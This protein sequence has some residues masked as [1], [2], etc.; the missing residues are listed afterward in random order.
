MPLAHWRSITRAP[1]DRL[2]PRILSPA[3]GACA[4]ARKRQGAPLTRLIGEDRALPLYRR[5]VYLCSGKQDCPSGRSGQ[6]H[7]THD[8]SWL[9]WIQQSRASPGKISTLCDS[10]ASSP[11]GPWLKCPLSR[12]IQPLLDTRNKYKSEMKRFSKGNSEYNRKYAMQ[13]SINGGVNT[14]YGTMASAYFD[15]SEQR[16]CSNAHHALLTTSRIWHAQPAA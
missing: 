1:I 7:F 2:Q 10:K 3:E 14:L 12:F 15:I 8:S 9:E 16:G 11:V 5:L 6:S 13:R 4:L